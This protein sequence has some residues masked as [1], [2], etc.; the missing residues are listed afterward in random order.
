[1][2]VGVRKSQKLISIVSISAGLMVFLFTASYNEWGE[3]VE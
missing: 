3:A 2:P 1:M